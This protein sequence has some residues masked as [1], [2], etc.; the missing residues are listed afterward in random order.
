MHI[1]NNQKINNSHSTSV[2]RLSERFAKPRKRKKS[3]FFS[4]ENSFVATVDFSKGFFYSLK[5]VDANS[6]VMS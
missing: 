6:P 3:K 5:P 1:T 4:I 2:S